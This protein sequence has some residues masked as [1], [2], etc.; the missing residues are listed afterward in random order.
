MIDAIAIQFDVST[1]G[2]SY[3]LTVDSDQARV[4][5]GGHCE[6]RLLDADVAFEH[7]LVEARSGTLYG[8][9]RSTELPVELNGTPFFQGRVLPESVVR[10]GNVELRMQTVDRDGTPLKTRQRPAHSRMGLYAVLVVALCTLLLIST[11]DRETADRPRLLQAPALWSAGEALVCAKH[12]RSLAQSLAAEHR[13]RANTARERAP[14]SPDEGIRA[15]HEFRSAHA[16]YTAAGDDKAAQQALAQSR[17]LELQL[18]SDYHIHQV[19]LERA[20]LSGHYDGAR[21]ETQILRAF[22]R[23]RSEP[24]FSW[25]A[26]LDRQIELKFAGRKER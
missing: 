9:V 20:L 18:S 1:P 8:E 21:V 25:L 23:R 24:Y 14:F 15:V 2:A 16:C 3:T 6:I 22:G 12:D 4:G 5:S 7:L 19:R 11:T 10:L 13:L 17:D 26:G